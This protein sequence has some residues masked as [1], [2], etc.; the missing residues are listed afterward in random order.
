MVYS[1]FMHNWGSYVSNFC[2]LTFTLRCLAENTCVF[3]GKKVDIIGT[4]LTFTTKQHWLKYLDSHIWLLR[5]E[6]LFQCWVYGNR[7]LVNLPYHLG[8]FK[9]CWSYFQNWET[10]G[11]TEKE[12]Q[13]IILC[14]IKVSLR[15]VLYHP[16]SIRANGHPLSL[17]GLCSTFCLTS[18]DTR[19][20]R[21]LSL[22]EVKAK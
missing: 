21:Y 2:Y 22:V 12:L 9:K 1:K 7:R 11:W 8:I 14:F 6:A 10:I 17:L 5:P 16:R 18:V 19:S 13:N 4:F 3:P 15:W 20:K